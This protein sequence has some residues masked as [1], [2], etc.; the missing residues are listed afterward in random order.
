MQDITLQKI[1]TVLEFFKKNTGFY[2]LITTTPEFADFYRLYLSRS[3]ALQNEDFFKNAIALTEKKTQYYRLFG[4]LE[5]PSA[6]MINIGEFLAQNQDFL[7]YFYDNQ[8]KLS[9]HQIE[10]LSS[11]NERLTLRNATKNYSYASRAENIILNRSTSDIV[12]FLEKKSNEEKTKENKCLA[13]LIQKVSGCMRDKENNKNITFT[14]E[15]KSLLSSPSN[16]TFGL[17]FCIIKIDGINL[18][19]AF[20]KGLPSG[21]KD[22]L[23]PVFNQYIQF[24]KDVVSYI[25]KSMPKKSPEDSIRYEKKL[26]AFHS[27]IR[28]HD[29]SAEFSIEDVALIKD[30]I[31][32]NILDHAEFLPKNIREVLE[33]YE[34]ELEVFPEYLDRVWNE[35]YQDKTLGEI[36]HG[37]VKDNSIAMI[38]RI[39]N[40]FPLSQR[41]EGLSKELYKILSTSTVQNLSY[42]QISVEGWTLP[43]KLKQDLGKLTQTIFEKVCIL[44]FDLNTG[45]FKSE[46][47]AKLKEK[48]P[49]YD[50]WKK[51]HGEEK[52][53]AAILDSYFRNV[54][55]L[56]IAQDLLLNP[57]L[58]KAPLNPVGLTIFQKELGSFVVDETQIRATMLQLTVNSPFPGN[59]INVMVNFG[60]NPIYSEAEKDLS[61]NTIEIDKKIVVDTESEDK[62]IKE[63]S[64]FEAY[65]EHIEN[66][67]ISLHFAL[68]NFQGGLQFFGGVIKK[69]ILNQLYNKPEEEKAKLLEQVM[70]NLSEVSSHSKISIDKIDDLGDSYRYTYECV[71]PK[72]N[73]VAYSGSVEIKYN[74]EE[75]TI[76]YQNPKMTIGDLFKEFSPSDEALNN[77]IAGKQK[78]YSIAEANK[79]DFDELTH[80][81]KVNYIIY[82]CL[83]HDC[84]ASNSLKE[85]LYSKRIPAEKLQVLEEAFLAMM[86]IEPLQE[87][88]KRYI[89]I[90][91]MQYLE[92]AKP[93]I[94]DDDVIEEIK[95]RGG[96]LDFGFK[97]LNG[98]TT[99]RSELDAKQAYI[100]AVSKT[101]TENIAKKS[102]FYVQ[103]ESHVVGVS[104]QSVTA[105]SS[106]SLLG[107]DA[108]FPIP[109]KATS[110]VE[111][112][113]GETIEVKL[114]NTVL[115][116]LYENKIA[117]VKNNPEA[118]KEILKKLVEKAKSEE[119]P[120]SLYEF[121][122]EQAKAILEDDF[123][124]KLSAFKVD[125]SGFIKDF[126]FEADRFL[127]Q[128]KDMENKF[129]KDAEFLGYLKKIESKLGIKDQERVKSVAVNILSDS[130]TPFDKLVI[131][132]VTKPYFGFEALKNNA[133]FKINFGALK[134]ADAEIQILGMY[135]ILN[136]AK[137][138]NDLKANNFSRLLLPAFLVAA[139]NSAGVSGERNTLSRNIV[140]S[141]IGDATATVGFFDRIFESFDVSERRRAARDVVRNTPLTIL[142]KLVAEVDIKTDEGKNNVNNIIS[143]ALS[144]DN[145]SL[146][147][148]PND[149]F[150]KAVVTI[151][152]EKPNPVLHFMNWIFNPST[153]YRHQN[154]VDLVEKYKISQNSD[155]AVISKLGVNLSNTDFDKNIVN[156]ASEDLSALDDAVKKTEE[157]KS[158]PSDGTTADFKGFVPFDNSRKNNLLGRSM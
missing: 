42:D 124:N 18:G 6:N 97:G 58:E 101:I 35:K 108:F 93:N 105:N 71:D 110:I 81:D 40:E 72:T 133:G 61:R 63:K 83:P 115:Q 44:L 20:L 79:F 122:K 49:N 90:L 34:N 91:K 25:P 143:I 30:T 14:D 56:A 48:Y 67:A 1:E 106:L 148:R 31:P 19:L 53:K 50:A 87:A 70:S 113:T 68:N 145:F 119:P 128:H 154:A 10:V 39:F 43:Y 26:H 2:K 60:C 130:L 8:E 125:Y 84:K 21:L 102:G 117:F 57:P 29:E 104:D 141:V 33:K 120:E 136:S 76:T 32:E 135:A 78:S 37:N 41:T 11:W 94:Y 118:N 69:E 127:G 22:I 92:V 151:A 55:A 24:Y 142:N 138:S 111:V 155:S 152:N 82:Y 75:K 12:A 149:N 107:N 129:N 103:G 123:E 153:Y 54:I 86:R 134:S 139:N 158:N 45:N 16:F 140:N 52:L 3:T 96:L 51:T 116:N 157:M 156:N 28:E 7:N 77:A 98:K 147:V 46:V 88:Q 121:Y 5:N 13:D 4:F 9:V 114:S 64:I 85:K 99:E 27:A 17:F 109:G 59:V 146:K 150:A 137:K 74:A 23:M 144:R 80:I 38:G 89:H 66:K 95:K 100:S 36:S 47:E 132:R 131:E 65:H 73:K 112:A 15:E 62:A 126:F